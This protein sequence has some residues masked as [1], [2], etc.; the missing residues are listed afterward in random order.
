MI[1]NYKNLFNINKKYPLSINILN[2]LFY[3]LPFSFILGN[4]L[5]NLNVAIFII[6]G[7]I[8]YKKKIF[9]IKQDLFLKL[10][11]LFFLY[12]IFTTVINFLDSY[13]SENSS[14]NDIDNHITN[15]LKSIAFLRFFLLVLIL[16]TML[17]NKDLFL[18][19]FFFISLFLC[20]FI[21]SDLIFQEIFC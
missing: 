13:Y 21:S 1:S 4:L 20:L 5:L 18:K 6:V 2:I 11:F 3:I 16:K 19:P 14:V 7:S 9:F 10:L 8:Y 17:T 12:L 15:V